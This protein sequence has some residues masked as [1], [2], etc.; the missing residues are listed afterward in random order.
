MS[1]NKAPAAPD[2]NQLGLALIEA[3]QDSPDRDIDLA[4][5]RAK[6]PVRDTVI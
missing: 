6:M 1:E 4:P 3:L 5:P 2:A